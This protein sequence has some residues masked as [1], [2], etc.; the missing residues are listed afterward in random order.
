M[1]K[2]SNDRS[3]GLSAGPC[4]GSRFFYI[5][6]K[7]TS[8][9][10]ATI[11]W[12]WDPSEDLW[13]MIGGH[14]IINAKKCVWE[15]E[16]QKWIGIRKHN[17]ITYY[18]VHCCSPQRLNESPNKIKA[19]QVMA[20]LCSSLKNCTCPALPTQEPCPVVR[21]VKHFNTLTSCFTKKYAKRWNKITAMRPFHG[22][23]KV[24]HP[25]LCRNSFMFRHRLPSQTFL[26][27]A[28]CLVS[29]MAKFD[30]NRS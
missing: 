18:Q 6:W 2:C 23:L 7:L 3:H 8:S 28:L 10:K 1:E 12:K 15:W 26:L 9:L 22:V 19:C 5:K 20:M 24:I 16:R 30:Q 29:V 13:I 25:Q 21:S 11:K 14:F 17:I 27:T 4:L